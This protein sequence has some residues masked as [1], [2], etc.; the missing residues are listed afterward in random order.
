MITA[1]QARG[2]KVLI[3]LY[4]AAGVVPID[5]QSM[6]ADFAIGGCYKY[7]RGGPGACWLYLQPCHLDSAF[8]TLDTGWF[9]QASPFA[10][11]RPPTP[12]LARG[13]DAFLEST[14]AILP[15]YQASAGL[16]FINALGVDRLR[17]YSLRQQAKLRELLNERKIGV[18]G[19][20]ASCGA[21]VAIP[22]DNAAEVVKALGAH[23]I[24][25]DARDGFLRL[26]PDILNTEQELA[27]AAARL[28][29]I[30]QNQ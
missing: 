17:A 3:D 4:H 12:R 2:A 19:T 24:R 13:G 21:F 11:E 9:A 14:P 28:A 10:F 27:S 5:L 1:A 8:Q 30:S 18:F 22:H 16:E 20:P 26:C 15:L 7:L 23:G 25:A 6:G 29:K